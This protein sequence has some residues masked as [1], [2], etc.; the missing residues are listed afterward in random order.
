MSDIY[1]L[2]FTR[3]ISFLE[4]IGDLEVKALTIKHF[5]LWTYV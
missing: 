4:D 3:E 1:A 2:F 5:G